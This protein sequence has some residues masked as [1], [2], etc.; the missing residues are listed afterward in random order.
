MKVKNHSL[1]YD[2]FFILCYNYLD[3]KNERNNYG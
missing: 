3:K 1:Y 2:F